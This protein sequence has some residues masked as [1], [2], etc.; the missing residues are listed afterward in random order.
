M[1]KWNID[2]HGTNIDIID[3]Q[4]KYLFKLIDEIYQM[5][6][7]NDNTK[8][9]KLLIELMRHANLHFKTEIE[10][11]IDNGSDF[12]EIK[13]H[14]NE[15]Y[16]I[17]KELHEKIEKCFLQNE[18]IMIDVALFINNWISEHIIEYDVIMFKK[19]KNK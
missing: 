7:E 2:E 11:L 9:K 19:L 12:E 13:K 1:H 6:M 17:T 15:H 5:I 4:H 3:E 8:I 18:N 10:Y 16:K 14:I